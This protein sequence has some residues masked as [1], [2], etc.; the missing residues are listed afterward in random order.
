MTREW[1]MLAAAD[2]KYVASGL[3]DL[4]V[5]GLPPLDCE[6]VRQA[7]ARLTVCSPEGEIVSL[8]GK[9]IESDEPPDGTKPAANGSA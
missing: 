9:R 6:R 1:L 8:A 7:R 2:A 4:M 5:A 3:D